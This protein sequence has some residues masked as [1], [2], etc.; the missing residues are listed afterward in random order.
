MHTILKPKELVIFTDGA[1]RGN[2][3]HGG[4]GTIIVSNDRVAELGGSEKNTTNNR[5][6]LQAIISACEMLKGHSGLITIYS[7]SSYVLQGVTKWMTNWKINNWLTK[8]KTEVLNKELWESLDEAIQHLSIEWKK[9]PGHSGVPGNE[10]ADGVATAFADGKN[11]DLYDGPREEYQYKYNI[12][13]LLDIR[14]SKVEAEKKSRSKM[15]AHSY[16]SLVDGV[17][18]THTTWD[19]CKSRVEGKSRVKYRKAVSPEDEKAIKEEW[20]V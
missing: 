1:S 9:L 4:W 8:Q 16:L 15:K 18:E 12:K 11:P 2:P 17:L 3:G 19:E 20:G 10:R 5:M 13:N 6:E 14:V 7:D